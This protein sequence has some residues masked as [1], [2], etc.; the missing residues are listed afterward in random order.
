MK[1]V[2]ILGGTIPDHCWKYSGQEHATPDQ[3]RRKLTELLADSERNLFDAVIVDD[4][5]RWSRDN[6][7]S[8]EG[9]AT[10]RKN[11]VQFFVGASQFDL[12]SPEH[13]LFLGM[14][15]EIN[16]FH[17]RQQTLKSTLN[18]IERA[19]QGIP[20]GGKFPYGRTFDYETC[21]W[22]VDEEKKQNI[23]WAADQYLK[24]VSMAKVARSLKMNH[25]NLWKILTKRC[26]DEWTLNFDIDQLNI[27]QAIEL[28]IPRL[29][30][31]EIIDAI[32]QKAEANKTYTHGHIKH[33]YLLSRMIFCSACGYTMFG[34]TNHNKKRYY[35]HPRHRKKQC[36]L[37]FWVPADL[38]EKAVLVHLF[39]MF[40][41]ISNMKKAMLKA[42]PDAE[43]VRKFREKKVLLEKKLSGTKNE[44]N[45]LVRAIAK[46]LITDEDAKDEMQKI[47]DKESLLRREIEEI[48]EYTRNI[49]TE[50]QIE[51][52]AALI[53]R[54]IESAYESYG[55]LERMSYE[56]KRNLIETA[57][58]GRDSQGRRFGI[59]VENTRGKN[60]EITF[61]I[62]GGFQG[63]TIKARLPMLRS[64]MHDILGI[65]SEAGEDY[66]P[67]TERPERKELNMLGKCHAYYGIGL[68]Q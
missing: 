33:R 63:E 43:Q 40:G 66:D 53:K 23:E 21:T 29:L 59:Y 30:P 65:E 8:K 34:Q 31:P 48:N 68:Y 26:G 50:S 11:G 16:E 10:L 56:D 45:K 64:E 47:R 15:T 41:D 55:R 42:I 18:R 54:T 36:T 7:R 39:K 49:P 67:L 24:G 5:S 62:V 9:L 1:N 19:K 51:R 44:K 6:K 2:E 38:I 46:D 25:P 58:D 27:H 17:A 4:A 52:R 32:H 12:F 57:F 28:K 20:T 37:D 3:E 60:K 13:C 22:G 14:A 35:R 61:T